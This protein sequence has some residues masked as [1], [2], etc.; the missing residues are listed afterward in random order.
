MFTHIFLVTLLSNVR[1][2]LFI[3]VLI[4]WKPVDSNKN[5][6]SKPMCWCYFDFLHIW[7]HLCRGPIAIV[8]IISKLWVS[9]FQRRRLLNMSLV[10][11][12]CC[13]GNQSTSPVCPKTLCSLA[14]CP[15][16]LHLKLDQEWPTG[17]GDMHV[18]HYKSMETIDSA[19]V[20]QN[21]AYTA[22]AVPNKTYIRM[23]HPR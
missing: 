9:W 8:I 21:P 20:G 4:I 13:H 14:H 18:F 6:V 3:I 11:H 1:H 7:Q 5:I 17:F 10:T 15:I 16:M 23:S 12:V 19:G 22:L 2:H